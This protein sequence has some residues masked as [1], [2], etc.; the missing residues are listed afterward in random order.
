MDGAH[1]P[2]VTRRIALADGRAFPCREDESVLEAM[3]R[4]GLGPKGCFGGGC[5]ACKMRVLS[6][7]Y[8]AFKRMSRAHITKEDER[9]GAVLMC[10]I[11]PRGDL[12][13]EE[14]TTNG[15]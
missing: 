14:T 5:G 2:G 13:L 7:A 15:K 9:E 12:L 1:E 3:R 8:Q 10:C 4:A 11:R 6:G